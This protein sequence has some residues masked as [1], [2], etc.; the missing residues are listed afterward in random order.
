MTFLPTEL[1][2]YSVNAVALSYL[3]NLSYNTSSIL[4]AVLP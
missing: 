1:T 3:L 4:S 2:Q